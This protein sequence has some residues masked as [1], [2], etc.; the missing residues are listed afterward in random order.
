MEICR[1]GGMRAA[2]RVVEKGIP[3]LDCT[4]PACGNLPPRRHAGRAAGSGER[5]SLLDCT[6]RN[7]PAG[8]DRR[9]PGSK[10]GASA[11]LH[12]PVQRK[13]ERRRK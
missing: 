4:G 11:R 9:P 10:G 1:P 7:L 12:R 13:K 2:Q 8:V 5:R 6:G 3:L